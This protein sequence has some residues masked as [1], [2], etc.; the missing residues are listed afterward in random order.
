MPDN[1]FDGLTPLRSEQ[2]HADAWAEQMGL[3]RSRINPGCM[4]P[5]DSVEDWEGELAAAVKLA[6]D[7]DVTDYLL[8][9]LIEAKARG[10]AD[11]VSAPMV[12]YLGFWRE[13][14]VEIWPVDLGCGAG[15]VDC[16]ECGGTGDWTP[17]HPDP[18]EG[19]VRCVECKGAGR[20][21]VSV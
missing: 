16:F 1:A 2:D 17:F 12:A 9:R 8:D 21:L 20:V 19:G 7:A 11:D 6:L 5:V 10:G 14:E 15:E 4:I 3:A 13:T 18:P